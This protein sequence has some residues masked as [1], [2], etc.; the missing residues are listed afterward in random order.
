MPN[1]HSIET[2]LRTHQKEKKDLAGINLYFCFSDIMPFKIVVTS[3]KHFI[4]FKIYNIW[5]VPF[6]FI[7]LYKL[8]PKN[9]PGSFFICC[10]YR[11]WD[12]LKP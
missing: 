12:Q 7:K 11:D 5:S 2:N 6:S 10:R 4:I 1:Y 8:R 9:C 3:N